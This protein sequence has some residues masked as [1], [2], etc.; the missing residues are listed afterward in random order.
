MNE[1]KFPTTD[2]SVI[3]V[4][5]IL[6]NPKVKGMSLN[7]LE[8]FGEFNGIPQQENLRSFSFIE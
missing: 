8:V 7:P 3:I 5:M 4:I 2:V 6:K 1:P